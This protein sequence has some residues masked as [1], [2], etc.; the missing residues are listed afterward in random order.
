MELLSHNKYSRRKENTSVLTHIT[1]DWFSAK[2]LLN[3]KAA[4]L[5]DFTA[6]NNHLYW[7]QTHAHSIT[8]FSNIKYTQT[9]GFE[10]HANKVTFVFKRFFFQDEKVYS[11]NLEMLHCETSLRIIQESKN[12]LLLIY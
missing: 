10:S 11:G 4:G 6:N 5:I 1:M 9:L 12:L 3:Y 8:L 2:L 7:I